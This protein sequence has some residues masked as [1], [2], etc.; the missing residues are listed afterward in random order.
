MFNKIILC[1]VLMIDNA[2]VVQSFYKD[3]CAIKN[4]K[5]TEV[6]FFLKSI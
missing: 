2:I 4:I 5:N 6:Q 1:P 3:V